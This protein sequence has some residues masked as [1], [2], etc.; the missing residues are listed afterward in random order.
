MIRDGRESA[1]RIK[2]ATKE[3]LLEWFAQSERLNVARAHY[4]LTGARF[5]DFAGRIGIDRASAYQL[6]KLWE[7]RAAIGVRMKVGTMAGKPV[8]TGSRRRPAVNGIET[9]RAITTITSIPRHQAFSNSSALLARSMCVP[10]WAKQCVASTSR[11]N[12]TD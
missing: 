12:R 8:Y 7:H 11:E 5:I 9:Q 6:V 3:A 1:A 2:R 4:G 10:Q